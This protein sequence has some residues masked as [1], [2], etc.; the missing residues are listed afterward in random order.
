MTFGER[1]KEFRESC[2]YTQEELAEMV[3]VAKTTITGYEKGNRK[4]DVPK[5]KKLAH[6]LGI[7]GDQLLGTGLDIN[8]APLYS[9]EAMRLTKD[10][11][12]LDRWGKQALRQVADVEM[13]RMED[14]ER[15]LR[16]AGESEEE[17]PTIPNF[18]SEPAAGMASPIMGEDYDEYTL[19]PGD[20]KGAVFSVRISGNSME[21]YFP[22]GSRVFC[23]KDPLRDG[24]IGVFSVDGE[25]VIKQYHY[26]RIL[27]ITYLF[28]LNRERADADVVI[29]RNSGQMLVCLGRVI[30]KRRFPLPGM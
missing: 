26:D 1:L 2:G 12:G 19:Q 20:P 18:W 29:T 22:N 28:S 17:K 13:A 8:K 15:F 24:D 4:P 16:D 11:D 30:T 10:Y 14:E 7:T 9:S 23:N 3:G 6:A 21:P 27:G 5:I 25:A